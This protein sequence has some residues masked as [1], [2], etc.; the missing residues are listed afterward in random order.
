MVET[1]LCD[2][3]AS[4]DCTALSTLFRSVMNADWLPEA[5]V[6]DE[7]DVDEAEELLLDEPESRF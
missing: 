4:P 7:D 1:A 5:V 6:P 3:V 2:V